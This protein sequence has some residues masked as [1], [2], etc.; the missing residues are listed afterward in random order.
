MPPWTKRCA[1]EA[2]S[3]DVVKNDSGS[4][5]C[6]PG[7]MGAR[8]LPRTLRAL[9]AWRHLTPSWRRKALMLGCWAAIGWRLVE[10]G[11]VQMAL[12]VLLG[13][14]A[15][16]RPSTLL[17]TR[18]CDLVKP[19][20]GGS[21]FWTVLQHRQ[22][23]A[24]P[25][26]TQ[27]Y[28]GVASWTPRTWMGWKICFWQDRVCTTANLELHVPTGG[29]CSTTSTCRSWADCKQRACTGT[30]TAVGSQRTAENCLRRSEHDA[31]TPS[32]NHAGSA[33]SCT[34]NTSRT[35]VA[36]RSGLRVGFRG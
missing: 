2:S 34:S 30:N 5:R 9:E 32:T 35:R 3:A 11:H 33:S 10:R 36:V 26:K 1:R 6:L 16:S 7:R 15:Y 18:P 27:R 22:E 12:Y 23:E 21:C 14:S 4:L 31:R 28:D 24:R 8:R 20:E 25:S 29:Q 19:E 13:L 17:A